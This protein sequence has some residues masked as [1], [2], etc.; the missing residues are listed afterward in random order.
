MEILDD[1]WVKNILDSNGN[2]PELEL[3]N[4]VCKSVDNVDEYKTEDKCKD[5]DENMN[6]NVDVDVNVNEDEDEDEDEDDE[7]DD[8]DDEEDE[9]TKWVQLKYPVNINIYFIYISGDSLIKKIITEK[10]DL[11]E[12]GLLKKDLLLYLIQNKT[13]KKYKLADILLYQNNIE[14]ID[15]NFENKLNNGNFL[16]I[17]P[18]IDNINFNEQILL[19]HSL[20]SIYILLNENNE[21]EIV[22]GKKTFKRVPYKKYTRKIKYFN[23]NPDKP[24][25]IK[26]NSKK[27]RK[28]VSFLL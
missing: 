9:D 2:M 24:T 8:D 1:D 6:V 19:F 12:N 25:I 22:N 3:N 11:Y 21:T 5:V 27:T 18:I 4:L 26:D 28:K 14:L 15:N 7:E 17:L 20:N 10:V 23:D 13:K 16:K